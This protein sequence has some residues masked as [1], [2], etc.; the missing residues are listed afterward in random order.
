M[1]TET[2]EEWYSTSKLR[3]ELVDKIK[4]MSYHRGGA[5]AF[6]DLGALMNY[7]KSDSEARYIFKSFQHRR[8]AGSTLELVIHD[9]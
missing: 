5:L 2:V 8:Y 6:S 7:A 9:G 1:T 3:P 4:Q